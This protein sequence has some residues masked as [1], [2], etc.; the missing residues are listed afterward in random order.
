[1]TKKYAGHTAQLSYPCCVSTLGRFKR[2]WS[3]DAVQKYIAHLNYYNTF[4]K[5][6]KKDDNNEAKKT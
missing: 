4:D 2:S 1:M 3:S 5:N 6:F